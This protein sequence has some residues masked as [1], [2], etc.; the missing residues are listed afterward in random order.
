MKKLLIPAAAAVAVV[1]MTFSANLAEAA[2]RVTIGT[3]VSGYSGYTT[4]YSP[5]YRGYSYPAYRSNYQPYYQSYRPS[6]TNGRTYNYQ[7]Y[8]P[9]YNPYYGGQR[10]YSGRSYYS[11]GVRVNSSG[12]GIGLGW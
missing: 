2:P 3:G 6:Y 10:Y 7:S 9:S 5:Y 8:R 12:I 11:P 1:A 4:G